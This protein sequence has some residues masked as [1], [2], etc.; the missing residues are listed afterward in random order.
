MKCPIDNISPSHWC[1][2]LFCCKIQ[3]TFRSKKALPEFQSQNKE[4]RNDAWRVLDVYIHQCSLRNWGYKFYGISLRQLHGHFINHLNYASLWTFPSFLTT[5]LV[6]ILHKTTE[7]PGLTRISA[8]YQKYWAPWRHQPQSSLLTGGP[9]SLPLTS[10]V[11]VVTT[12]FITSTHQ[13]KYLIRLLMCRS[14]EKQRAWGCF[15]GLDVLLFTSIASC[16][17]NP[18][19]LY[20]AT[21]DPHKGRVNSRQSPSCRSF[22]PVPLIP[23]R[24]VCKHPQSTHSPETTAHAITG[25][26]TQTRSTATHPL[27]GQTGNCNPTSSDSCAKALSGHLQTE[28]ALQAARGDL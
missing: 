17:L 12:L 28:K 14:T 21:P 10:S 22:P 24:S 16:P 2:Q 11:R 7:H 25:R 5:V 19:W 6:L 26:E 18:W 3:G 27:M 8:K 20:R 4:V 9:L 13:Q 1:F 23:H 15:L